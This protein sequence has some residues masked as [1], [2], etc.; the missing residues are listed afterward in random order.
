[1]LPETIDDDQA[2]FVEPL[3][4]AF[5]VLKQIKLDGANG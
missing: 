3:A 5:Q 1:V 4:A 2:V